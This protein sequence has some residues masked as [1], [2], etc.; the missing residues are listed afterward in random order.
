M[1]RVL[2]LSV[3]VIALFG[4][5]LV[6]VASAS[7]PKLDA[8]A[9][10]VKGISQPFPPTTTACKSVGNCIII[11][12]GQVGTH[13]VIYVINEV[14]GKETKSSVKTLPSDYVPYQGYSD[15][16]IDSL[17][18][19]TQLACLATG[20]Y[21]TAN[22]SVSLFTLQMT[23]GTWGAVTAVPAF[24]NQYPGADI[25]ASGNCW[26]ASNCLIAGLYEDGQN[27]VSYYL[28]DTAG[29]LSSVNVLSSTLFANG[30][31]DSELQNISC[32]KNDPGWCD[33]A[34]T[35][36]DSNNVRQLFSV[37]FNNGVEQ[38]VTEIP[39]PPDY[40]PG[41]IANISVSG[42]SCWSANNCVAVGLYPNASS[43][44]AEWH[45]VLVQGSW[46]VAAGQSL[47]AGYVQPSQPEGFQPPML[48]CANNGTCLASDW[49]SPAANLSKQVQF[50]ISYAGGTWH[51][52]AAVTSPT[53]ASLVTFVG[54]ST[55]CAVFGFSIGKVNQD[56]FIITEAPNGT[57][58]KATILNAFPPN[59]DKKSPQADVAV[60]IAPNGNNFVGYGTYTTNAKGLTSLY[61]ID[62]T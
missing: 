51:A 37:T 53:N 52:P 39:S 42:L 46:T 15:A 19:P 31:G 16:G 62:V 20:Y 14:G 38:A 22:Q 40:V 61:E 10:S 13:S 41:S 23:G 50:L 56:A 33:G 60:A 25:T 21:L 45:A 5:S 32:A 12:N 28:T 34:G 35:Y 7:T 57:V 43:A 44:L 30:E 58:A 11:G 36:T 59:V 3:A 1:R 24:P 47:P 4:S 8:K 6:G 2:A 18:C 26:T 54:G 55:E 29:V 49:S 17:S 48:A 27:F 9:L